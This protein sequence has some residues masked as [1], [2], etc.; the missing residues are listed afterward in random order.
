MRRPAAI[1]MGRI[2]AIDPGRARVGLAVSDP[3]GLTATG[4]PTYR[5]SG[6]EDW[7]KF[8]DGLIREWE[9]TKILIGDPRHMNGE[10]SRGSESSRRWVDDI[11]NRWKVDVELVDERLTSVEAR[12]VLRQ[13]GARGRE[14]GRVDKL[15]AVLLLQ[16]Y[17]DST[18]DAS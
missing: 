12:N 17:L 3:L 11:K 18:G 2:L 9:I 6:K 14:K 5:F 13:A 7:L 1:D 16:A 15:A 4:L 10:P 8:L